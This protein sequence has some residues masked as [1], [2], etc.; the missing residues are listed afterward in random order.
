MRSCHFLYDKKTY[1]NWERSDKQLI[2]VSP[3]AVS[4]LAPLALSPACK[5]SILPPLSPV[6]KFVFVESL[7]DGTWKC[8]KDAGIEWLWCVEYCLIFLRLSF[9]YEKYWHQL[10]SFMLN[11]FRVVTPC[12][13]LWFRYCYH[14]QCK[15]RK[16]VDLEF[17]SRQTGF[18]PKFLASVLFIPR[19]LNC[20]RLGEKN[21]FTLQPF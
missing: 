11:P 9:P 15:H 1:R 10:G 14:S 19:V 6:E 16:A 4:E 20:E 8:W 13:N 12:H 3:P 17:E 2:G 7:G 21:S 5:P 18:S